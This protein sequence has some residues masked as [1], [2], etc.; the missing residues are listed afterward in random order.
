MYCEICLTDAPYALDRPF[1]YLCP[2]AFAEK[3]RPGSL[4]RVRQIIRVSAWF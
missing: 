1:D 2:P 4:V 3:I